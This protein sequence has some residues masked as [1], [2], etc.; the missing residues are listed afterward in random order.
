LAVLE[1][2]EP[3]DDRFE[4]GFGFLGS[5]FE[6]GRRF[7]GGNLFAHNLSG[8]DGADFEGEKSARPN[9]QGERESV[10]EKKDRVEGTNLDTWESGEAKSL[11]VRSLEVGLKKYC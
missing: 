8:D 4:A 11:A 1:D 9:L 3:L 10:S 7:L 6:D 5:E 2:L